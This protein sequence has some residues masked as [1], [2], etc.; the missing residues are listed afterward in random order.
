M[1]T[2]T[3]NARHVLLSMDYPAVPSAVGIARKSAEHVL[4][5]HGFAT[6]LA[7]DVGLVVCELV[8]NAVKAAGVATVGLVLAEDA[9]GEVTVEV[10][11][12][13]YEEPHLRSPSL[14]DPGGRG[15]VIVAALA[16]H[17]GVRRE[18][19]GKTVFAVLRS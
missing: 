12:S 11:D 9:P 19:D 7:E 16:H 14:E 10:W 18:A 15:L 4:A 17:Y 3:I 5:S 2:M 8:T 13:S 6:S 1:A